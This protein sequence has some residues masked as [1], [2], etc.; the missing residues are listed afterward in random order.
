MSS[1]D[2]KPIIIQPMMAA[3]L[4]ANDNE[5]Q[6]FTTRLLSWFENDYWNEMN[7]VC[8]SDTYIYWGWCAHLSMFPC[9]C[10]P[11]TEIQA[12]IDGLSGQTENDGGQIEHHND[13]PLEWYGFGWGGEIPAANVHSICKDNIFVDLSWW[14]LLIALI[15]TC[16]I[17]RPDTQSP[18]SRRCL[19]R[20][21]QNQNNA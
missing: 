20:A 18:N 7:E 10:V 1:P 16:R 14:L 5:F 8:H 17:W 11:L 13:D 15:F 12:F 4:R 2:V 9:G 6:M 3:T 19:C 21:Q